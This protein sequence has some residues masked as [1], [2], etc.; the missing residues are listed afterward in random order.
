MLFLCSSLQAANIVWKG[1]TS[2]AWSTASNW[3]TTV[4]GASDVAVFD[5]TQGGTNNPCVIGAS[6]SVSG[7]SIQNYTGSITLNSTYTLTV[8]TSNY[9]QSS[10]TFQGASGTPV[11]TASGHSVTLSAGT[12]DLSLSTSAPNMG[13]LTVNGGTL[14]TGSGAPTLSNLILSSGAF[15]QGSGAL[16]VSNTTNISGGTFTGV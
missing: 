8:G 11:F 10:G 5:T 3:S 1:T 7:V 4:P 9:V 15:T 12:F 2:T 13:A 16:T 14:L 6:Y